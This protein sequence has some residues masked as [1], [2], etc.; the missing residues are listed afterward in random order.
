MNPQA[1]TREEKVNECGHEKK[2]T[3]YLFNSA[4]FF[5]HIY[6]RRQECVCERERESKREQERE[7]GDV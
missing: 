4:V 6:A 2:I 7:G 5:F 1:A 3:F